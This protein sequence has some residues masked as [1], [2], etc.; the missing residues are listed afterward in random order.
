MTGLLTKKYHV[1]ILENTEGGFVSRVVDALQ[2]WYKNKIVIKTYSDTREMFEA[3]NLNKAK[4]K[5]FDMAVISPELMAERMVLQ[6]ANPQLK[7]VV[8]K[9]HNTF[10]TE[11]S[12]VLL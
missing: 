12:K 5:P 8:C 1:A 11:T 3:V 4:N 9:D 2:E 7:V 10:R 6:R